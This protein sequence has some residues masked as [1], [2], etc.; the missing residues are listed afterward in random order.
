M[1]NT[2]LYF[3]KG[4]DISPQL[5]KNQYRCKVKVSKKKPINKVK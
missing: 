4:V 2:F 3:R 5:S 1:S